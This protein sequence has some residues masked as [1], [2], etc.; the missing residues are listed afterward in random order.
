MDLNLEF[1]YHNVS[2][3]VKPTRNPGRIQTFLVTH[4]EIEDSAHIGSF[5]K[6][7]IEHHSQRHGE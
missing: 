7:L 6:N 1:F 3:R 2:I 5:K 4:Q